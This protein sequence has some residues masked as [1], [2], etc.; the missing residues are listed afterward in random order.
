[1]I[2][3]QIVK[4]GH[5]KIT[6]DGVVIKRAARTVTM[7]RNHVITIMDTTVDAHDISHVIAVGFV[8]SGIT[9]RIHAISG[10]LYDV[11]PVTIWDTNLPMA[12]SKEQITHDI[13]L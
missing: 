6:T 9:A 11:T 7:M 10:N 4:I 2:Q 5:L 13:Y 12:K 8:V 3:M 1:M